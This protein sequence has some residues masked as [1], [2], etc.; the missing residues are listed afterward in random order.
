MKTDKLLLI[1][2]DKELGELLVEFLASEGFSL[3]LAYS[4]EEGLQKLAEKDYDL[5]LLDVM[6][7][8]MSGLDVLREMRNA[9]TVPVLM[10]TAKGDEL[11]KVLGLELGADDYLPKPYSHR[12]LV[13]RIRALLRRIEME[14][15]RP[16]PAVQPV[17]TLGRVT[18][19]TRVYQALIDK[20][21]LE[22]TQTEFKVLQTLMERAG[23]VVTK[24]ELYQTVLGRP[25]E[26]Y[27]RSID[28]HVS[29]VRKKIM[30]LSEDYRPIKT[31]RGVGYQ[32]V[33]N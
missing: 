14:H 7:P 9:N 6:M 16:G 11:D 8:G 10:L 20:Q 24:N 1:D 30:T 29:N 12:E 33:A 4:G 31:L 21:D 26:P 32:F 22:L 17:L 2:D 15:Q 25:L 28:M 3:E 5:I 27:D 19:D 23:Q 18:L 13:A